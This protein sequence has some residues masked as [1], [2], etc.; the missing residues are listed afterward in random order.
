M[1]YQVLAR[2][3]R[4]QDFHSLVGQEHVLRA[5]VH[6][7]DEQ[8]LH[9][10][11]LFAGT[12]G[13]GK[14]TIARILARC[15]NCEQGISSTPCGTCSSCVEISEGRFVDLI[16][17]DAAS[18]T[19]V[20][21]TRELLENVQYAPTRGRF[22]VY[23]IDEV[24]MLSTSS[25]N[26]LLKTLEE[27]PPHVKFLLATTDPHK[28][29][30]TVLS[31]CLQFNLKNMPAEQ[32]A[33]HLRNVLT[34]EQIS[35]DEAAIW[36]LGRAAKGSMRDALSLTDQAIAFCGG[37]LGES[38]VN[39]MLGSIDQGRVVAL[40]QALQNGDGA[41]LL[42]QVADLAEQGQ[43][44]VVALE[45]LLSLLHQV[46]VSQ[47]VPDAPVAV[48][49]DQAMVRNLAQTMTA[50][51]V[52]LF[53]QMGTVAHKDLA[54][55][56][57]VR[58]GFEMALLRMLAFRPQ[59]SADQVKTIQ[60][61]ANVAQAAAAMPAPA[62]AMP[63]QPPA[64]EVAAEAVEQVEEEPEPV[65]DV[66]V[67]AEPVVET[68]APQTEEVTPEPVEEPVEQVVEQEVEQQPAQELIAE[69][70]TVV[71]PAP[72]A[73]D[74]A[75][76]QTVV[77]Q[78][79]VETASTD[80]IVGHVDHAGE[81]IPLVADVPPWEEAPT[82]W[83]GEGQAQTPP[84]TAQP[85]VEAVVET[86]VAPAPMEFELADELMVEPTVEPQAEPAT[87]VEQAPQVEQE[88]QAPQT[89]AVQWT[90]ADLDQSNWPNI[91][92]DLSVDGLTRAIA[93]NMVF[94]K[95]NG[96]QLTF[97]LEQGQSSMLNA[98]HQ[99]RIRQALEA[100]FECDLQLA[101][102]IGTPDMETPSARRERRLAEHQQQAVESLQQD[103]YV[104]QLEQAF[105]G[106]LDLGSIEPVNE[107]QE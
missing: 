72:V 58:N 33:G 11:Y 76:E 26:A 45:E 3:W 35:F 60:M 31:R 56:P 105:N 40:V 46:A 29:P 92:R 67:V 100:M 18:R 63:A 13:V 86:P 107:F 54:L 5:L 83:Q 8:R 89:P 95:R 104:Q 90:L 17:V 77:E 14:T 82:G 74:S 88:P 22:K 44:F 48:Q 103:P 55:A 37:E 71:E 93:S 28:L 15:L 97:T 53:Y 98:A 69:Q 16:E 38:A 50:A 43:S 34:Q 57:D 4:P 73:I 59:V 84:T 7:L 68:A 32:V 49:F 10:A 36:Q 79:V 47:V 51:D 52:Q 2:K 30:I 24:H 65:V 42:Q 6:A 78:P 85:Q 9:H 27:P 23:L 21:D 61:G 94:A 96:T 101:I 66:A 25:F 80:Q 1:A 75:P 99:G 102:D 106:Q 12:R 87:Q 64:Q 41:S 81:S 20:E 19:K 62:P 70:E 39:Q 91:F